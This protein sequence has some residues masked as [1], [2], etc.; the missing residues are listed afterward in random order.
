[1]GTGLG[2]HG[3]QGSFENAKLVVQVGVKQSTTN[4]A[5][6][7]AR[8]VEPI[9]FLARSKCLVVGSISSVVCDKKRK[10]NL[11]KEDGCEGLLIYLSY[12]EQIVQ[13][14]MWSAIS[15]YV[16]LVCWFNVKHTITLFL[17]ANK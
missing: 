3:Q 17:K 6:V 9:H 11:K 8:E 13:M 5:K 14:H 2:G 7:R 15:D 12:L 16:L 1:M 4:E 10:E